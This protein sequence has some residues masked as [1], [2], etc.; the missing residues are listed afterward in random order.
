VPHWRRLETQ[1]CLELGASVKEAR[2]KPT[3]D[4]ATILRTRLEPLARRLNIVFEK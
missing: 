3:A 1:L 4:L 2:E